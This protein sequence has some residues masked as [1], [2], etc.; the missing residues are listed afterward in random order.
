LP[1][2]LAP[3]HLVVV[4]IFKNKEELEEIKNY[5]QPALEKIKTF[6]LTINSEF[7]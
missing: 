6:N 3:V 4:P 7:L 1:P 2:A 5:L